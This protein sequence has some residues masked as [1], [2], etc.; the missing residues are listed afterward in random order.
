M[1]ASNA[2]PTVNQDATIVPAGEPVGAGGVTG[3]VVGVA[4]VAGSA[5][6]AALSGVKAGA[7]VPVSR[8]AKLGPL[9]A[10][11]SRGG[12][13]VGPRV[14]EGASGVY[15]GT[16]VNSGQSTFPEF[17]MPSH[18]PEPPHMP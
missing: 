8:G 16:G 3:L 1:H 11:A 2:M 14:S 12:L 13:V 17:G 9:V 5:V 15:V 6:G 18:Q 10:G 7:R 4:G